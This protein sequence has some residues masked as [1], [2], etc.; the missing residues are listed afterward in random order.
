MKK[1]IISV[2][3]CLV[4]FISF[5]ISGSGQ[6]S[7]IYSY[8]VEIELT[9]DQGD[10]PTKDYL[11][12]YGTK[13]KK[14]GVEFIYEVA[15]PFLLST[16]EKS[17]IHVLQVDTLSSVKANEYGKPSTTLA[18]AIATGIADQYIKVYIKDITLPFVE[19]LTQTDPNS[20][21]KKLV[22]IRCR[23]QIYDAKKTLL[24]DVEGIFQSGEKIEKT[25][26]LGVDLRK[27]QGSDYLQE[28]KIYET[29]TKM[30]IRRA[31]GQL[32]Q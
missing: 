4:V 17:G 11:K 25:A 23:I 26:D 14:Q 3:I 31:A 1:S 6:K 5:S 32:N 2:I 15:T 18:K 24:K 10:M 28:L 20:Q 12:N 27:Y 16:L 21:I 8:P 7:A 9:N 13:G 29:C 30:A 22:K 19:G